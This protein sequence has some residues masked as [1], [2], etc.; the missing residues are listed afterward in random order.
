[1]VGPGSAKGSKHLSSDLLWSTHESKMENSSD[2]GHFIHFGFWGDGPEAEVSSEAS[3]RERRQQHS[4]RQAAEVR[5][6][7]YNDTAVANTR[8]WDGRS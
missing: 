7:R 1:M 8:I 5:V 2:L 6:I 3:A 4:G